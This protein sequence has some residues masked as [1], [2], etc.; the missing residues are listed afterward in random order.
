MQEESRTVNT[1][2]NFIFSMASYI[3]NMLLSFVTRTI[4]IHCLATEYLGVNGLFS[5]ILYLLSLAELGAGGAF[6]SLLYKPIVQKNT[7]EISLVMASFRKAYRAIA[8]I[9]GIIGLSLTPFLEVIVG[10]NNIKELPLIYVLYIFNSV[11]GYLCASE[12]ALIKADE[13]AYIVTKCTQV[14][15]IIQY[16]LQALFLVLT[17]NYIVYLII[18]IICTIGGNLYIAQRAVKMY[19][20]L[21][22]KPGKLS[23]EMKEDIIKKIKGGFCTHFGYVIASGTDSIVIS[24]YLGLSILGIYSNYLMII[25][26]IEKF[27]MMVFEAARASASN[28]VVSKDKDENY[29][30][31]KRMNF[32]I[33][34]LLGFICTN[35]LLLFNSFIK[36]W[37]GNEYLMELPLVFLAVV[38]YFIGWHGIK[39]PISLFREAT[40]LYYN[41]RYFALLEG[42][43]NVCISIALVGK[44]GLYGVLIGTIISSFITTVSGVY[45][46]FRHVFRRPIYCYFI[47]MG[48]Y[49]F[50]EGAIGAVC[51][52]ICRQLIVTNWLQFIFRTVTCVVVSIILYLI[53]FFRAKEFNYFL[54]VMKNLML[55]GRNRTNH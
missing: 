39:L 31:F 16:I 19:S 41:D 15:Y 52:V 29:L 33:M 14:A 13:K 37:I 38:V 24:H 22:D 48:K 35:L 32:F 46:V 7:E 5:N 25:G 49:F 3:L 53:A 9:I 34:V 4:F 55:H 30:F 8:I 47:E 40:G 2:R 18:Q 20:Y 44:M 43:A 11:V 23:E 21:K 17:H 10:E 28:Y 51:I 12:K 54:A 26:I 50:I 27:V 1:I 36:V 42:I 45:L 6:V